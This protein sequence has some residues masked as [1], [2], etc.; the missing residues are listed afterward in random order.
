M[1]RKGESCGQLLAGWRWLRDKQPDQSWADQFLVWG[2]PGAWCDM[3]ICS[4]TSDLLASRHPDGTLSL[5][6][7][8]GSQ[9]APETLLKV[10]SN[11]QAQ[12][13]I[14]PNGTSFLQVADTH[15]HS[16]LK[17]YIRQEKSRL[18]EEFDRQAMATGQPRSTRWGIYE[19][20]TVLSQALAKLQALQAKE[21][22]VLRG[23]IQNQLLI[24]RPNHQHTLVV[25]DA[26]EEE[27]TKRFPRKPPG[28][29]IKLLT[30]SA[31][32]VDAEKWPEGEPPIPDWSQLDGAGN[33]LYQVNN[34]EVRGK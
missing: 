4:W 1:Y 25:Y 33:Y 7:C 11:Q 20:A 27:W 16:P 34:R 22:V 30:S 19:L 14:G 32:I 8:L 26:S 21:D 3:V 17:A 28:R 18:S 2:Q 9:W 23:A 12:N 29:G 24:F 31:R 15:V 6:D 13:A 10:W 5:C